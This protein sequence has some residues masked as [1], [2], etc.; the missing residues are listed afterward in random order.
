VRYTHYS[1]LRTIEGALGL[2]ALTRNDR[3]AHALTDIFRAGVPG[4]TAPPSPYVAHDTGAPPAAASSWT[5]P[6]ATHSSVPEPPTAFVVSSAAGTVTPITLAT[7]RAE[8]PIRVGH[9]PQAVALSPDGGMAYVVNSGS[10]SV[11]PIQT[12]TRRRERAIPVGH[13]PRGIAVT[14]DGRT[15]FV[16]NAGADTVTLLNT[17]THAVSRPIKV[18]GLPVAAAITR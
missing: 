16:S 18:G 6:A 12:S 3:Y 5:A 7:R 11:T 13:D 9:N 1:L 10:D 17:R 14:P 8:R 2:H 15:A 4:A